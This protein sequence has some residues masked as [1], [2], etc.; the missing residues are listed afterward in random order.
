VFGQRWARRENMGD[1]GVELSGVDV[2]KGFFSVM[3]SLSSLVLYHY[4]DL[5]FCCVLIVP[6][7]VILFAVHAL[8]IRSYWANAAIV[9]V[10]WGL[11]FGLDAAGMYMR[12]G[13]LGRAVA[14]KGILF[15]II[16]I[17][18]LYQLSFVLV[19]R[20]CLGRVWPA[21]ECESGDE[22]GCDGEEGRQGNV[23]AA[24]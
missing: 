12:H 2:A 9:V 18:L 22:W 8:M 11:P 5:A 15:A 10:F 3:V 4:P 21:A 6:P 16:G 17:H 24:E 19:L 14:G 13:D 23:R 1:G 7:Y 20:T